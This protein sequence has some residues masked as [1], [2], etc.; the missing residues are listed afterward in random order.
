MKNHKGFILIEILISGIILASITAAS[1]YLFKIGYLNLA[2]ADNVYILN[3]KI[4][5]AINLIKNSEKRESIEDLGD[6][7]F[8]RWKSKLLSK[9][10]VTTKNDSRE[11]KFFV[12]LYLVYFNLSMQDEKKDYEIYVLKYEKIR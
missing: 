2:K 3:S 12:Y 11:I 4:P 1:M 7:V 9:S 10:F 6:G 5:L 8:L